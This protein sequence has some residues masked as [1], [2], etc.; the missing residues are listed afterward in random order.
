[1]FQPRIRGFVLFLTGFFFFACTHHKTQHFT[2][3]FSQCIGDD[4][5]RKQM[6]NEMKI[7]ASFYDNVSLIIEDAHGNSELQVQ[8]IQSLLNKKVN[9]LI[10]SPNESKPVTPIAEKAYDQGTPTIIIDRKINSDKY[11]TFIGA[12]NYAIG[13]YTAMFL[14]NRTK[15]KLKILEIWG[16]EGSSPAQERHKG[17]VEQLNFYPNFSLTGKV[18]GMWLKQVAYRQVKKLNQLDQFDI[19]FGHNEEMAKGA[20]EAFRDRKIDVRNKIFVG[21]DALQGKEGG[22]QAVIDKKLTATLLY[23]TGGGK[24]IH[25]A[26]QILDGKKF[27][28]EYM[29][30]T[31][32]VDSSNARILQLQSAQINDY[33]GKIET[34]LNKLTNLDNKYNNQQSLLYLSVILMILGFFLAILLYL[35]YL[36]TRRILSELKVKNEKI[37]QQREELSKQREQLV[38]MNQQIEE[39]SAQKLRFFTN[40][41]HELRTPLSLLISPLQKIMEENKY[42]EINRELVVMKN[43]TE[44]LL[45]LITQMLDFKKIEDEHMKLYVHKINIVNLVK[46]MKAAFNYQAQIKEIE[47]ILIIPIEKIEIYCDLDKIEKVLL[48]LLSNAFKFSQKA[49]KIQIELKENTEEVQITISDTG[50]GISTDQLQKV[51]ERFYQ[52]TGDYSSG[53]G[54]GLNLSKEYVELHN[55]RI[56]LES[57]TGV[58]S[59]FMVF[60]KKGTLHLQEPYIDFIPDSESKQIIFQPQ[61]TVTNI[62]AIEPREH[63]ILVVED[64]DEMREYL[65]NRLRMNYSI[66]IATNGIEAFLVLKNVDINLIVCDVM[67]PEMDGFEFCKLLK[68]DMAYSHIPVILLTA[69]VGEEQLI[70]GLSAGADDY[71][72]KPF[73]TKH[74]ELKIRNIL[75]LKQK[76]RESFKHEFIGSYPE[77]ALQSADKKF[78][79]KVTALLDKHINDSEISVEKISQEIG[80]SRI[81]LYRKIKEVT[82]TSPS[83]FFKIYKIKKSMPLLKAMDLSISEIAYQC[84]FSSPAYY[85]KCFKEVLNISPKE[86]QSQG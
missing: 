9:L 70:K 16:L 56:E 20:F 14:G 15:K 13:K 10:I 64:D 3:G 63:S 6:I 54:I 46:N 49:D 35:A 60:L 84:G 32:I 53:T 76:L 45:R 8:Q 29:L 58:G 1:M 5:W 66:Y 41:S 83:E 4:L 30:N 18:Q 73:N 43:N 22:I 42:P 48:N 34:Q 47:F 51:F 28:K 81:H 52:G 21:V 80:L 27:E 50:K 77:V 82:G 86:Y 12:D 44:R 72:Y 79:K 17:F 25:V 19:I 59:S 71:L 37:I 68:N 38:A 2:I 40:V 67:M 26:L 39:V 65:S 36:H 11:S 55:G 33:L 23:P 62:T 7:E 57:A 69:L 74:L 85:S 75:S 61:E 31:A 24:A 78:I